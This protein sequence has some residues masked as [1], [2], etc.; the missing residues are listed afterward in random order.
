MKI[1]KKQIYEMISEASR[2]LL[3]EEYGIRDEK[4]IMDYLDNKVVPYLKSRKELIRYI[5]YITKIQKDFSDGDFSSARRKLL[6]MGKV[7]T[8]LLNIVYPVIAYFRD[9]DDQITGD[10]GEKFLKEEGLLSESYS[11]MIRDL[12][13]L[14][15]KYKKDPALTNVVGELERF[16]Q[17]WLPSSND[18]G[19]GPMAK[20]DDG[21][22]KSKKPPIKRELLPVI[23]LVDK[24]GSEYSRD[25]QATQKVK[26]YNALGDALEAGNLDGA[27][28]LASKLRSGNSRDKKVAQQILSL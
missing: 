28:Q 4:D 8:D 22:V 19:A 2:E 26:V 12:D 18:R 6:T 21:P 14:V 3:E 25:P 24:V 17:G 13:A 20:P 27:K 9:L 5:P 23:D 11:D 15:N 10:K 7:S 16:I 1:T